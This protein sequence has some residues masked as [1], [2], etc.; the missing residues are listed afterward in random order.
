MMK[1]FYFILDGCDEG[2][3]V[4]AEDLHFAI[5]FIEAQYSTDQIRSISVLEET[6]YIALD[7]D[8]SI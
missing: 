6:F 2:V 7:D 5:S 3:F 1:V 4:A 8:E